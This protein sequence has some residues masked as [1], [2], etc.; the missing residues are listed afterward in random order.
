M[1]YKILRIFPVLAF[2]MALQGCIHEDISS[3]EQGL[4]LKLR[5]SGLSQ[6][7][8]IDL[9]EFNRLSLYLYQED[10][11]FLQRMEKSDMQQIDRYTYYVPLEE[12]TY[13]FV[14]WAGADEDYYSEMNVNPRENQLDEGLLQL[15][16]DAQNQTTPPPYL[17]PTPLHYG[18]HEALQLT[19]NISQNLIIDAIRITSN[20]RIIM[21]GLELQE[22][23][24]GHTFTIVDDNGTV[25][26]VDASI[27]PD[28]TVTYLPRYSDM[29]RA[30]SSTSLVGYF[31]TM[32]LENGRHPQLKL[33]ADSQLKKEWDLMDELIGKYPEADFET[34]ND[35]EI[36][37]SFEA[38]YVAVSITINGWELIE[39]EI[40]E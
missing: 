23:T 6:E 33:Y 8:W 2:A 40:E 15:R 5:H 38:G 12:G 27:A 9:D 34:G 11:T 35:Y 19:E 39:Q 13:R 28:E 37:F 20:I 25:R 22:E 3:C 32:R 24:N 17:L 18:N 10:G 14:T 21:R 7:S 30:T 16:R 4:F 31:T 1:S 36:I 29:L 26:F